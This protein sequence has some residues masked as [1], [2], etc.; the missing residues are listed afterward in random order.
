MENHDNGEGCM[1]NAQRV[2]RKSHLIAHASMAQ[3]SLL[4]SFELV[5]EGAVQVPSSTYSSSTSSSSTPAPSQ[6]VTTL[7]FHSS[8]LAR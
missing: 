7:C 5:A 1:S 4:K 6:P 3:D 2:H 8:P